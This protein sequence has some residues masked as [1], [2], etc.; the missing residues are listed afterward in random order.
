LVNKKPPQKTYLGQNFCH[1]GACQVNSGYQGSYIAATP[2]IAP[3]INPRESVSSS[4]IANYQVVA[5]ET[6]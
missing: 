6:L 4:R 5:V 2:F 1:L 3:K